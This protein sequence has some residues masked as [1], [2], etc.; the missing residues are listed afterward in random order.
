MT[1]AI[2]GRLARLEREKERRAPDPAGPDVILI[3]EGGDGGELRAAI[4]MD[5]TGTARRDDETESEFMK[6]AERRRGVLGGHCAACGNHPLFNQ[7]KEP[8]L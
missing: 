8:G 7:G 2:K 5:G 4:F 6:R 1:Q 3:A